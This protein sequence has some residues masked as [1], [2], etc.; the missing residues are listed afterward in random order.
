[1][2]T[3]IRAKVIMEVVGSPENHV[4]DVLNALIEKIASTKSYELHKKKVF[5]TKK[6][7]DKPLWSSFAEMEISYKDMESIFG[8]CFDFMPS[9]VE[10]L[11]PEEL[12]L[13]ERNISNFVNDLLARLHQYD[14]I[15]KNIHAEN[16]LL[17][18]KLEK[19]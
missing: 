16:V 12:T 2:D 18:R 10:I 11:A 7:D 17:K 13:K 1:M 15:L 8:F 5:P 4:N 9:S 19:A 3:K 14:M 6:M